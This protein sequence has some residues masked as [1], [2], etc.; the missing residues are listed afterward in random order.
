[1]RFIR[2]GTQSCVREKE[3]NSPVGLYVQTWRRLRSCEAFMEQLGT[4]GVR[5]EIMAIVLLATSDLI[6]GSS[7]KAISDPAWNLQPESYGPSVLP[8]CE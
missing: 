5:P 7:H 1:M 4:A 2:G 8:W 6:I 3:R